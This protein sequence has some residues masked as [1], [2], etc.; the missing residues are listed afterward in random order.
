MQECPGGLSSERHARQPLSCA[1]CQ[2]AY[3]CLDKRGVS[4]DALSLLSP[5][6]MRIHARS[7]VAVLIVYVA[8][9]IPSKAVAQL[10]DSTHHVSIFLSNAVGSGTE[11]GTRNNFGVGGSADMWT[12]RFFSVRGGLEYNRVGLHGG[13]AP[14][15]MGSLSLDGVFHP[16]PSSWAVRPYLFAGL[17]AAKATSRTVTYFN[18]PDFGTFSATYPAHSWYGPEA[19]VG[20]EVGKSFVQIRSSPFALRTA[21][22]GVGHEYG[23]L[24][25]GL[26]F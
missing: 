16:A 22:S 11:G 8:C 10:F 20:F 7:T 4:T 18:T 5:F 17:G 2:P 26:H 21:G 23:V 13:D 6:T 25:F 24:S 3:A 9:C 12:R 1:T 19:G 15:Q 14:L